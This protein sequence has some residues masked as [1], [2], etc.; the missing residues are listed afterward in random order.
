[1][2]HE[3]FKKAMSD[4]YV[5]IRELEDMFP[6]RPFAPD[7]HLVGSL[8]ECLVADAYGLDLNT[9]SNEGYDAEDG[10][11]RKVEIKATQYSSVGFRSEPEHC[12]V[13]R[14]FKDGSFEEK[15]NGPGNWIWNEFHGKPT[16]KNGQYQ[17]SLTKLSKLQQFVP[18]DG[19]I[20]RIVKQDAAPDRQRR[21]DE[22]KR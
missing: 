7:G 20:Q 6:G 5:V 16:P 11:G 12:I 2:D 13:I 14:I 3:R 15:Y 9:P 10:S 4:L 8:G 17:I 22:L 1:M 19:R 21:M 18:L